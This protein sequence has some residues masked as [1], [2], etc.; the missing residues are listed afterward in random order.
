MVEPQFDEFNE[1]A[2]FQDAAQSLID[3]SGSAATSGA[4]AEGGMPGAGGDD[5]PA[6][7]PAPV[8]ET[9]AVA[10]PPVDASLAAVPAAVPAT[11]NFD[12]EG[13]SR[14]LVRTPEDVTRISDEY[15]AMQTELADLRTKVAVDPFANEF[16]KTLDQMQRDGKSPDQVKAF[17]KLQDLGDISKLSPI[18]AMIEAKVLRDGRNADIARKQIERK[19]EITEGMD[20]IDRQIAEANMADDAKADYEYLL[21]QKKELA[22][23]KP[24]TPAEAVAAI[25]E[26]VIRAEV[27]PIKQQVKDQFHSLGNINLNGKVDKDGKPTD[28]AVMFD[29]PIPKEFKDQI[30]DLLENYFVNSGTKPTKEGIETAMGILQY[31]MFNR[32]GVKIIQD[33]CNQYGTVVEK[34]IRDEYENKNPKKTNNLHQPVNANLLSDA[35]LESYV[36]GE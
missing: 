4:P 1:D 36:S 24:A 35:Q 28:E 31:E 34:R 15:R 3:K 2:M 20:E 8:V 6:A 18:D 16:V 10:A 12:F 14:G 19:Y 21:S 25:S 29:L 30:P 11:P 23:P 32:F 13:I 26:E 9:P 5:T 33:A 27:A 22:T 7:I 17:I